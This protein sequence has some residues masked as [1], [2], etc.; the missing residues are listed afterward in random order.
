MRSRRA[1]SVYRAAVDRLLDSPSVDRDRVVPR[2]G[3]TLRPRPKLINLSV[4]G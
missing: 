1:R 4:Y 3:A 2:S